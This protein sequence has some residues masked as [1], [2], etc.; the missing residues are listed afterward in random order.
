MRKSLILL[1]LAALVLSGCMLMPGKKDTSSGSGS[2]SGSNTGSVVPT[3]DTGGGGNV[4]TDLPTSH[5]SSFPTSGTL[6]IDFI[7]DGPSY[8]DSF[9]Y[10]ENDTP[11]SGGHLG[12]MAIMSNGCYVGSYSGKGFMMMKNKDRSSMGCAFIG[13][14]VS[15][16]VI[17]K[18]EIVAPD[19]GVSVAG[20]QKYDITLSKEMTTTASTSGKEFSTPITNASVT[21]TESDGYSYFKISTKE[22]SKNGHIGAIKVTYKIS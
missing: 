20:S 16:G 10:V 11:T 14:C 22:S 2:G 17:T 6:E 21:A 1:P 8:K 19:S 13:N 12:G 18:V 4:P 7:A 3:G 15:L 5:D 9:P